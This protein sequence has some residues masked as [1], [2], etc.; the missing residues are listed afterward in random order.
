MFSESVGLVLFSKFI[1]VISKVP[2]V[3]NIVS[4]FVFLCLTSLSNLWVRPC[5]CKAMSHS[6]WQRRIPLRVCTTPSKSIHLPVDTCF[7]VSAVVNG[8]A[9][10][11]G[12][13]LISSNHGSAWRD[14][15]EWECRGV[16]C[17]SIF[18][19]LRNPLLLST[20]PTPLT[21]WVGVLS[22]LGQWCQ[23][24]DSTQTSRVRT[25]SYTYLVLLFYVVTAE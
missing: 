22:G 8:A 25:G 20:A 1:C 6:S 7:Q 4:L 3:H 21:P 10:D 13:R 5:C 23:K 14:A 19:F 18:S 11:T 16:L 2:H 9:V 17:G 24:Q 12:V 15:Q